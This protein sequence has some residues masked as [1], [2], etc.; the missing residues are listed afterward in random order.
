MPLDPIATRVAHTGTDELRFCG[1][2]VFGE[3]LGRVSATQLQ[4]LGLAG[5]LVD[6]DSAAVIDDLLT[7][8]SSADPRM[9][10]FKIA[11]LA[12]SHGSAAFGAAASIVAAEGGIFGPNRMRATAQWLVDVRD[13]LGD[14]DVDD[15][16]LLSILEAGAVAFGVLYRNHDER[17]AALVRQLEARGRDTGPHV[18]LCLRIVRVGREQ[19]QLEPHVFLGIAAACLD[20]GLSVDAT[21]AFATL[22]LFHNAIA[23]AVE[24][25]RQR[26]ALL[27]ELPGDVIA[28]EGPPARSSPRTDR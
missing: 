17:F 27:R 2:R 11:R 3:L 15:A 24:G 14:R 18:S 19:R 21:A 7:V 13:G 25:A 22:L 10:P 28:Y 26:P 5:V 23:N 12:A 9:W 1:H 20:L 4:M 16:A 8:M 6:R